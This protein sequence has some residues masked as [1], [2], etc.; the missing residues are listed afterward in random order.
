MPELIVG[1]KQQCLNGGFCGPEGTCVC[2]NGWRGSQCEEGNF[3]MIY[4]TNNIVCN[5]YCQIAIC[6]RDC[7]NGGTCDG[8]DHCSCSSQWKGSNCGERK[9]S[10]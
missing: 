1:C 7:L 2:Q 4:Y 3:F 10:Q 9:C 6:S 5:L 8:P